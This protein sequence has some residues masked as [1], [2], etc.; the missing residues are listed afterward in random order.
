MMNSFKD[1]LARWFY[2]VDEYE[3]ESG[4]DPGRE[5]WGAAKQYSTPHM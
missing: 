5:A 2:L 4:R 3:L 1:F